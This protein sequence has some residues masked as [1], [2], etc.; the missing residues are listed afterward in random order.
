MA[1]AAMVWVA[2]EPAWAGPQQQFTVPTATPQSL[3]EPEE[4][5]VPTATPEP[6]FQPEDNDSDSNND[7]EQ[8][9]QEPTEEPSF[10]EPEPEIDEPEPQEDNLFDDFNSDNGDETDTQQPD[11]NGSTGTGD[12][13]FDDSLPDPTFDPT[14]DQTSTDD[15][16]DNTNSE[17][18]DFAGA[19]GAASGGTASGGTASGGAASGGSADNSSTDDQ[20]TDDLFQDSAAS[21][22]TGTVSISVLNLRRDPSPNADIIDTM[23]R[24]DVVEIAQTAND[25]TWL[26]VCCG[27]EQGSAGWVS[28]LFI[29]YDANSL[30][31]GSI[32]GEQPAEVE[33]TDNTNG[34][35]D[36]ETSLELTMSVTD[37]TVLAGQILDISYEVE[38]IGSVDALNVSV[39]NELPEDLYLNNFEV[40][41]TGSFTHTLNTQNNRRIFNIT[42]PE[43][44]ASQT[45]TATV[46]VQIAPGAPNGLVIDNLAGASAENA[47]GDTGAISIGTPP[48]AP[49][50]FR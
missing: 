39:T 41:A 3:D 47:N 46:K 44:A 11:N 5:L 34:A 29:N 9:A 36:A 42:W 8:P 10:F 38:N 40:D 12:T 26:L 45:V 50:S 20:A 18:D 43:I 35:T 22:N 2:D 33:A 32:G 13:G 6:L 25:G 14:E 17:T 37:T 48:L 19:D 15:F 21:G 23:W 30:N 24:N 28:A 31:V 4:E 7:F 16:V 49:P 27:V 1:I